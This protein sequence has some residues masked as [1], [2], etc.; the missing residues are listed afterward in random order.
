MEPGIV[1]RD[2]VTRTEP[3][4]RG[5]VLVTGSHGGVYAA[6]LAARAGVRAAIFNDA[7]QGKDRAGIAGLD[8]LQNLGQDLGQ[9]LGQ[10]LGLAAAAVAHDSARIGDAA[11]SWARGTLSA[12][13]GLA[14]ALG[15]A[16][17]QACAEAARALRAAAPPERIPPHALPLGAAEA[18]TLLRDRP[19][20]P[21]VWALDSAS[22]VGPEHQGQ[23]LLIGSH[24]GLPGGDPAAALTVDA[25]AAVY[26]DAGIGIDEAGVSRLPALDARGIA[27]ATVAAA[28]ARIGEGRSTYVDGVISR[29]NATAA[30]LGGRPGMTAIEFVEAV[31]ACHKERDEQRDRGGA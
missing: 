23:V 18:V 17:G 13:N 29:V 31:L 16:I 21:Q 22:L 14:A 28:S 2:S 1:L 15:C 9:N 8:T 30:A 7:G 19:G 3:G 5:C 20:G 6:H 24:G 25:L 4:D 11:D 26:N 27:G 10:E 12:V